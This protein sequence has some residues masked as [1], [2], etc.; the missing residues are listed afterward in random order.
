MSIFKLMANLLITSVILACTSSVEKLKHHETT[1]IKWVSK[2]GETRAKG[3]LVNGKRQGLWNEFTDSG[4]LVSQCEYVN[5]TLDGKIL[6]YWKS[7]KLMIDGF[8]KNNLKEGE[9][10][11]YYESGKVMQKGSYKADQKI[12]FWSYYYEN[13][14]LEKKTSNH[15]NSI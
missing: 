13:G 6:A 2:K 10:V 14:T 1:L 5:N 3:I 11:I 4:D 12:G 8:H 9:W 7:G 15:H